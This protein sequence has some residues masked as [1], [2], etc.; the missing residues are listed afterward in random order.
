MKRRT[1]GPANPSVEKGFRFMEF[2]A[3]SVQSSDIFQKYR[4]SG[5]FIEEP[6]KS[7][8]IKMHQVSAEVRYEQIFNMKV[9]GTELHN[10]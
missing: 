5:L 4:N 6:K 2:A 9:E 3:H 1:T 7:H 10:V 8:L